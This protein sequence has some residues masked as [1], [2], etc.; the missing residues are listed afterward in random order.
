M[1]TAG[2]ASDGFAGSGR[3][4]LAGRKKSMHFV[5]LQVHVPQFTLIKT[6]LK[7]AGPTA[8]YRYLLIVCI[9]YIFTI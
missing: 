5:L 7:T 4:K 1:L 9:F 3:N 8:Y 6:A 2:E